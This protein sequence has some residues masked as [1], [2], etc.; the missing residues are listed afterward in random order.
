MGEVGDL[1]GA[2]LLV[3]D[4]DIVQFLELFKVD[5]TRKIAV[6]HG[7]ERLRR[8]PVSGRTVAGMKTFKRRLEQGQKS[9][10]ALIGI[11]HN[12]SQLPHVA[13]PARVGVR[14]A[15]PLRV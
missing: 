2:A 5:M 10:S 12:G 15:M 6:H 7:E 9:R 1:G 13:R 3:L 8:E 4:N 14:T 11:V